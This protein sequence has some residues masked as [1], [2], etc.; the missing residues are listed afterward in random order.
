VLPPDPKA[1]SKLNSR[2][3]ELINENKRM[4]ERHAQEMNDLRNSFS[5]SG[6]LFS[7]LGKALD[8]VFGM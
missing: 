1:I 7:M 8:K 6:G 2:I 3:D 5:S 4:R